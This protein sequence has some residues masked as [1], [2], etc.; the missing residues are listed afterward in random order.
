MLHASGGA[1]ARD[2]ARKTEKQNDNA[3][4]LGFE[5]KLSAPMDVAIWTVFDHRNR[6][7][8]LSAT[9]S[10]WASG[11][12]TPPRA[13]LLVMVTDELQSAR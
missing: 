8:I 6:C 12:E 5:D 7:C 1:V 4:K 3:A 9:A 10:A 11:I 2:K 13:E